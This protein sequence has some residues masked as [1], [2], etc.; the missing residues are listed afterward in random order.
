VSY[1]TVCAIVKNERP[2]LIEW[3]EF[4]RHVGVEHFYIYDNGSTDGSRELLERYVAAGIVT[5]R[6]W[7]L[8]PG[9]LEAYLD[10]LSRRPIV[11]RWTAF[12]DVDEYLFSPTGEPLPEVLR[13]F[14]RHP[15]VAVNWCV[16]GTSGWQTR[17]DGLVI[18]SYTRRS[19]NAGLNSH[20]KSIVD[21]AQMLTARPGDPHHFR[22]LPGRH[23]VNELG[24]PVDGPFSDPPSFELLR[25]N[26]YWT[27]SVSE[28]TQKALATERAD[29][30]GRRPLEAM[31]SDDLNEE[32][33]EAVVEIAPYVRSR[34][35][36]LELEGFFA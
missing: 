1:L 33:D 13:E 21:M 15:G 12:I 35:A 26:H 30:A 31:L 25:L 29:N 36:S 24:V 5:L 4:H 27:K 8:H 10:H 7:P 20:V 6:D 19:A 17:P 11:D 2:Y 9:Q 34:I 28:A 16:F 18:E 32:P 14:E 23:V 22:P 3:I